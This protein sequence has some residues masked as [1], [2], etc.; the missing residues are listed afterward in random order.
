MGSLHEKRRQDLT[1]VQTYQV[2]PSVFA[3]FTNLV[4]MRC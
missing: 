4:S 3:N 1:F 2:D